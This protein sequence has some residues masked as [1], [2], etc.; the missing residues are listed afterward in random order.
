[1][2]VSQKSDF[3]AFDQERDGLNQ[4]VKKE[5]SNNSRIK[6]NQSLELEPHQEQIKHNN[7]DP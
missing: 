4:L 5:N 2:K 6:K 7:N 1:M 3:E